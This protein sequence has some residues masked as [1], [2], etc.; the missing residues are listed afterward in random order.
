MTPTELLDAACAC[1]TPEQ[2][3]RMVERWVKAA[4]PAH[5][6]ELVTAAA[7]RSDMREIYNVLKS[8]AVTRLG[9]LV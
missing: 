2:G 4:P 3:A 7:N 9:G 5:V 1:E 8:D 6:I